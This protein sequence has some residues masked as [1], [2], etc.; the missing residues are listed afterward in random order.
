MEEVEIEE[1]KCSRRRINMQKRG[2]ENEKEE[3]EA[4]NKEREVEGRMELKEEDMGKVKWSGRMIN[5]QRKR[6][7]KKWE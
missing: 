2:I 7:G 1:D 5:R 3:N 4:E 6:R